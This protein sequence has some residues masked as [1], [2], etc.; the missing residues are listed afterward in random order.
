M[1]KLLLITMITGTI[2]AQSNAMLYGGFN[3]M[4]ESNYTTDLERKAG[5][6]LGIAFPK[7][8]SLTYGLGYTTKG[9]KDSY[10]YDLG[11][12]GDVDVDEDVKI[13]A[14]EGWVTNTL[15]PNNPMSLFIGASIAYLMKADV[16]VTVSNVSESAS[17]DIDEFEI[18]IMGG[19][20][21]KLGESLELS[22]GYQMA[23]NN[24]SDDYKFNNLFVRIGIPLSN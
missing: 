17:G 10:Y 6:S 19:I 1:K 5:I 16:D 4:G 20:K 11:Y 7:S 15:T 23:L 12:Y 24:V 3:S 22:L 9:Y 8:E 14:I 13:N 21:T 18:S 2:Y